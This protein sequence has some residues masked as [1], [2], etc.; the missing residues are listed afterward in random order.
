MHCCKSWRSAVYYEKTPYSMLFMTGGVAYA[1]QGSL[2]NQEGK[3]KTTMENRY[4]NKFLA[5]IFI[6]L[7]FTGM[8]VDPARAG[9]SSLLQMNPGQSET[10][11]LSGQKS[12][13]TKWSSSDKTVA[14]VNTKGIVK[15]IAPGR[16]VI[17][18]KKGKSIKKYTV[19]V[20]RVQLS[21]RNITLKAGE[22]GKVTAQNAFGK[23]SW[24]SDGDSVEVDASGNITAV[25]K[26]NAVVTASVFGKKY[27]CA[28]TVEDQEQ[29]DEP[30]T[31]EVQVTAGNR[32]FTAVLYNNETVRA[33]MG[34]LPVTITMN[35]L[36]GNEKYHYFSESLPTDS[37]KPG[38]IHTGDI[39]L[40]GSECLV[41]FYDDFSTS[42]SYTPLGRISS[43]D[44]LAE[45]LGSG[46]VQ[47]SFSCM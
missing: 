46:N 42:Y 41:L 25:K 24:S 14:K 13:K 5:G 15:A 22:T 35:E 20:Q 47:V 45:A 4:L 31:Y 21:S 29:K 10:I 9:A 11:K 33:F 18:A 3:G 30:E 6:L 38:K 40:Y 39:M 1:G 23:I 19:K 44:G 17:T 43:P 7:L 36:N 34:K 2:V 28:V 27:K 37:R 26:G 32:K 16:A 8:L 12:K